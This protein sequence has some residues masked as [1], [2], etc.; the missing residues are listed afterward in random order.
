MKKRFKKITKRNGFLKYFR[1]VMGTD[2]EYLNLTCIPFLN[3]I[4]AIIM[5]IVFIPIL[6]ID[7]YLNFCIFYF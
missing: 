1:E 4:V 5:I 2:E 7:I 6:L 3:I